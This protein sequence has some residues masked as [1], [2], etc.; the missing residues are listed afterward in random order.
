MWAWDLRR[1]VA[2]EEVVPARFRPGAGAMVVTDAGARVTVLCSA[3]DAGRPEILAVCG[4]EVLRPSWDESARVCKG[5]PLPGKVAPGRVESIGLN[6]DLGRYLAA[7]PAVAVPVT[8]D[9]DS[10][11]ALSAVCERSGLSPEL[12]RLS[13]GMELRGVLN[14]DVSSGEVGRRQPV[15]FDGETLVVDHHFC[16]GEQSTVGILDREFPRV[17]VPSQALELAHSPLEHEA[18][19]KGGSALGLVRYLDRRWVWLLA[20]HGRLL[21][22]PESFRGVPGLEAALEKASGKREAALSE[23]VRMVGGI[24]LAGPGGDVAGFR[25]GAS[26]CVVLD[27]QGG[28]YLEARAV[29]GKALPGNLLSALARLPGVQVAPGSAFAACCGKEGRGLPGSARELEAGLLGRL[30]GRGIERG[31]VIELGRDWS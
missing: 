3:G 20:N 24:A 30:E 27:E 18:L 25:Q 23:P 13:P 2:A 5:L 9:L 1:P 12:A 22:A 31:P 26:A 19:V 21:D 28:A 16:R 7:C 15:R 4:G 11:A 29:P 6:V 10:Q 8:P 17:S 14:L